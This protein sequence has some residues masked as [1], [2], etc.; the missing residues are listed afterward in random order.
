MMYLSHLLID[1]G[2]NPDRPRPGRQW[3]HNIYH[4]HQRLWMA[5][6]SDQ[7]RT[8]DPKFLRPFDTSRFGL[9][10]FLF[11]VDTGIDGNA[12]RAIILVLSHCLPDWT[13][14]FQNAQMLLAAPPQCREYDPAF[15]LGEQYSFRIR[16]NLS[17]KSREHRQMKENTDRFGRQKSQGKRVSLTW[18]NEQGPDEAIREWFAAK[19]VACGFQLQD[20]G[21]LHLGWV[22]GF[23]PKTTADAGEKQM[24][25][26]S[27]LLEGRL[28]VTDS[29][30]LSKAVESGIGSAKAFGFGLL[31]LARV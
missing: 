9:P 8:D 7:Q 1:V 20:I 27:A 2:D 21:V 4:V 16:M 13:Y 6:P 3:L 22:V 10:R 18:N 11:R 19:G 26:R 30:L 14:A 31:S 25:F 15:A 24:R 5:F 23:R 12:P 17:K 28:R 29:S